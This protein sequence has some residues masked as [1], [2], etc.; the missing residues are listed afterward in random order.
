MDP[1]LRVEERIFARVKLAALHVV[2]A[3]INKLREQVR[4][5]GT[6]TSNDL[7]EFEKVEESAPDAS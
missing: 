1:R 2:Q 4:D 3:K 6:A 5:A 7:E